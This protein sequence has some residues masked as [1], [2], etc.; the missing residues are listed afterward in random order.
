MKSDFKS[1]TFSKLYYA[2]P[3]TLSSYFLRK[4]KLR[5]NIKRYSDESIKHV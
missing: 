4:K 3:F 5:K 2:R 1:R